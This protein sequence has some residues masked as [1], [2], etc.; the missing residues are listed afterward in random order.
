M[1]ASL[2]DLLPTLQP[3]SPANGHHDRYHPLVFLDLLW[4]LRSCAVLDQIGRAVD[5]TRPNFDE[6][7]WVRFGGTGIRTVRD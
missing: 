4:T 2:E 1:A 6:T 3:F 7:L 5:D